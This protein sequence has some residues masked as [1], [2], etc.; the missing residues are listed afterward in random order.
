VDLREG[1]CGMVGVAVNGKVVMAVSNR[2]GVAVSGRVG[3][4]VGWVWHVLGS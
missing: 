1:G 4:A 2:M 3:V